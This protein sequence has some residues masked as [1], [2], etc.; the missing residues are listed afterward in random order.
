MMRMKG[1]ER[2]NSGGRM[3]KVSIWRM[4]AKKNSKT[5][6]NHRLPFVYCV[7]GIKIHITNMLLIFKEFFHCNT[8][9]RSV[10]IFVRLF[11]SL[12]YSHR[13]IF[14]KYQFG[15]CE[16]ICFKYFLF[17]RIILGSSHNTG[18][19]RFNSL[20]DS[21]NGSH[22]RKSPLNKLCCANTQKTDQNLSAV[23]YAISERK[24]QLI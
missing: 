6:R 2:K 23:T 11:L 16:A 5:K 18:T 14:R 22:K 21:I 17:H 3:N 12:S 13:T 10:D 7:K 9:L 24:D 4:S 8:Q 1:P 15:Q 20:V 19:I